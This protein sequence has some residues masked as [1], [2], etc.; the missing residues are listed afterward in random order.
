MEDERAQD[1]WEPLTRLAKRYAAVKAE[2][3]AEFAK[4]RAVESGPDGG[5]AGGR[6]KRDARIVAASRVGAGV[7][8]ATL[9]K[10]VWLQQVTDD[11]SRPFPVRRAASG[12]LERIDA[13]GSVD[14]VY[15]EVHALAL[16]AE[17]EAVAADETEDPLVR[18]VAGAGA[19]AARKAGAR[20]LGSEA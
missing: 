18:T 7:S 5:G 10:V 12:A 2:V 8:H 1:G 15:T 16:T 13:G 17:L 11:R 19:A 4:D 9:E 6:G 20:R 3:A 14:W